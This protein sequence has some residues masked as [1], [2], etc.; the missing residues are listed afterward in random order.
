MSYIMSH[1]LTSW[2]KFA[3]QVAVCSGVD[4]IPLVAFT[5]QWNK[6]N[7]YSL[8]GERLPMKGSVADPDPIYADP[9]PAFHFDAY[10]D[11]NPTF[12]FDADPDPTHSL[13]FQIWT[14]PML[15]KDP[16]RLPPFHFDADPASKMMHANLCGSGSPTLPK[17]TTFQD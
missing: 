9:D 17:C 14:H 12:Q 11:P 13:F 10:P 6:I 5:L 4:S 3:A 16:Q 2:L 8:T 7:Q 1:L 15:Q